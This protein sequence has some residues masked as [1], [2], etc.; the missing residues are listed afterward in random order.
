MLLSIKKLTFGWFDEPLLQHVS[1][2]LEEG[3]IVLLKGENGSGK[4]TLL[5]LIS[6]MI[7]HFNRGGILQGDILIKGRSIFNRSPKLFFPAIAFIPSKHIEFFLFNE[8]LNEEIQLT[9][10]IM[11]LGEKVVLDKL[12]KFN[13]IFPEFN[14]F[15]NL[16]LKKMPPHQKILSLLL[17]Y[18]LQ[19]A[20]L[21][22]LDDIFNNFPSYK[23]QTNWFNFFEQQVQQNCSFIFVSHQLKQTKFTVWE[24]NNRNLVVQSH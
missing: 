7:P 15:K 16:S 1:L 3:Q 14:S 4:T 20:S 23:D 11:N 21:Y 6:G 17:I 24:I 19:G 18:Y 9:R 13:T 2:N 8:N 5:K 22:L 10:A 12:A